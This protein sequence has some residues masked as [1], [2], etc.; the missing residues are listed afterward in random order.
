M[1]AG[2]A[3]GT[4]KRTCTRTRTWCALSRPLLQL[5]L[6]AGAWRMQPWPKQVLK[7]LF[8]PQVVREVLC[9][10][11][12]PYLYRTTPRGSAKRQEMLEKRGTF[13]VGCRPH[14]ALHCTMHACMHV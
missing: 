14:T 5:L 13:Q 11:E 1:L 10:L 9:E 6:E 7:L 8:F 3:A 2:V 4:Y 12:L